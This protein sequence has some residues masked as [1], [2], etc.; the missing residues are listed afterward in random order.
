M[1]GERTDA[2]ADVYSLGCVLFAA[3]CG[4]PPFAHGTVPATMLAHLNDPPP[5]PS[6]RGAPREFDR[7]IARALAKR[8]GA[9]ATRRPATSAARRWPPRAASAVTESERSVGVGSAAPASTAPNGG[10]T[11]VLRPGARRAVTAG[12]THEAHDGARTSGGRRRCSRR[13]APHRARAGERRVVRPRRSPAR[14]VVA[15][16]RF[17]ALVA[18]GLMLGLVF[19]DPDGRRRGPAR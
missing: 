19:G 11:A 17:A 8:P 7:V 14:L 6:A 16:R 1:Q 10:A 3:L 18:V 4:R 9:T 5:L 12:T 15:A 2:R 13:A